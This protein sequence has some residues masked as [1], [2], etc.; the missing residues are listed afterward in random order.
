MDIDEGFVSEAARFPYVSI[1]TSD[2]RVSSKILGRGDSMTSKEVQVDVLVA[3][4]YEDTVQS[5][6]YRRM[7]A[8][9]WDVLAHLIKHKDSIPGAAFTE[10]EESVLQSLSQ[11][12]GGFT[13]WGYIGVVM[14]PFTV[15]FRGF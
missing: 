15:T 5:R 4:E 14:I 1:H 6:G 13:D 9:R 12:T 7:T 2:A 3:I 10:F 11:E 8:L